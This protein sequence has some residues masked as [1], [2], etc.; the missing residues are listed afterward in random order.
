MDSYDAIYGGGFIAVGFSV[1]ADVR[2]WQDMSDQLH[3]AEPWAFIEQADAD[4]YCLVTADKMNWVLALRINGELM[5]EVQRAN[6]KRIVACVNACKNVT[7]EQLAYGDH[8]VD[9]LAK[10][11]VDKTRQRNEHLAAYKEL[12]AHA[13]QLIE[14]E[15]AGNAELES[16]LQALD[17]A[18]A[19]IKKADTL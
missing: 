6:A 7:N 1:L 12:L 14:F 2:G 19:Y 15:Y 17:Y 10:W 16:Q 11:G 8:L 3:T 9:S 13:E 18:R 5:P 4:E